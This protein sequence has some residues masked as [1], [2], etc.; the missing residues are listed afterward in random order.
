MG[1]NIRDLI[2]LNNIEI[3][4]FV[5]LFNKFYRNWECG[6]TFHL[7]K[8]EINM[9][10]SKINVLHDLYEAECI[11]FVVCIIMCINDLNT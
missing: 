1:N 2:V 11:R 9:V 3:Y 4:V 10:I 8:I 6:M 7:S 5:Q